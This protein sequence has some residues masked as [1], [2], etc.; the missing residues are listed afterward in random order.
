MDSQGP[1]PPSQVADL[2]D[3]PLVAHLSTLGRAGE[4]H[5]QPVWYAWD[6][7]TLQVSITTE[8]QKF[9]NVNR[10]PRVALSIQDPERALHYI[11]VRGAVTS[12]DPDPTGERTL[13]IGRKYGST[14]TEVPDRDVRIILVITPTRF[15]THPL[16][17][18]QG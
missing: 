9:R 1:Q 5:T 11:E 8:R 3:R 18:R 2:L 7:S 16:L 6:G 10:D 14:R 17:T 12:L 4:P 13:A 15:G